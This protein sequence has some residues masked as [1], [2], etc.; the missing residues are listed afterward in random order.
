MLESLKT[1]SNLH[2]SNFCTSQ[3][4]LRYK[5]SDI[6]DH[7]KISAKYQEKPLIKDGI[8]PSNH[9]SDSIYRS[10]I[11]RFVSYYKKV[12]IINDGLFLGKD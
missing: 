9:K 7:A 11:I 1:E 3:S 4:P 2:Q 6:I 12:L 10:P 8:I 5:Q